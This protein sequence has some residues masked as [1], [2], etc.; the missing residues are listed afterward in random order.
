MLLAAFSVAEP[1]PLPRPAVPPAFDSTATLELAGELTDRHPDRSPGRRGSAGWFVAQLAPYGF[2]VRRDPFVA[3][4]PG[5]GRVRLENL[6]AR[7]RGQ[8]VQTIVVMAHRD[9]TGLTVGARDNASGTAALIELART[10]ARRDATS[11]R[12]PTPAQTIV[13]LSTDAGTAGGLGAVR[14]VETYPETI[15]A[16]INLDALSGPHRAGLQLAAERPR[17]PSATLVATASARLLEQTG[18]LP[19]R[20]G[21]LGQLIDLA[22]P[23]SLYEQAPF[24]A[25]GIPAITLTTEGERPPAGAPGR[26][27]SEQVTALGRTAQELLGSLDG[28]LELPAGPTSYVYLGA[29]LVQGW[30]I[31]LVLVAALLPFL[32]ATVDLYARCRRR[33]IRLAPAF[34]SYRSRF[35]FWGWTGILFALG[36]AFGLWPS[37]PARP[38]APWSTPA[39]SWPV[40]ALSVVGILAALGWFVA[41]VRLLPR[42]PASAEEELAG[43]T[44]ALLVLAVLG[45]LTV[46]MNPFALLFLLP[47][48][49]AWLWLPQARRAPAPVRLGLLGLGFLGPLLLLGSFAFRFGLGLDAPWY[50]LALVAVGYVPLPAVLIALGWLAAGGQLAALASG[51]YAPYPNAAEQPPRGPLRALARRL[52]LAS[53]ARRRAPAIRDQAA[54]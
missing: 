41:R 27:R 1:V 53:R 43:H 29:R 38:L 50:V 47:S 51:R 26:L 2:A 5:R 39:G 46:A 20:P 35:A 33:R 6:V 49:H 36:T 44:A 21:A 42:R 40:V 48:L 14:F 17:S 11:L 37:G 52:L 4:I 8:S 13:F 31:Q 45:L 15:T 12:P 34:R 16:V 10:Y 22:F 9:N 30:A 24:V 3:E 54:G 18:A 7:T 32:I 23:F 25:R 28:G 19:R